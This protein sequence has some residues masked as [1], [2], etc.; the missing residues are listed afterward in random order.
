MR[1]R[2]GFGRHGSGLAGMFHTLAVNAQPVPLMA[3]PMRAGFPAHRSGYEKSGLGPVGC[4]PRRRVRHGVMGRWGWLWVAVVLMAGIMG[5]GAGESAARPDG[6]ALAAELRRERPA[7]DLQTRGVLRLRDEEGRWGTPVPMTLDVR[8]IGLQWQA[9]YRALGTDGELRELLV[10]LH[11]E[12]QPT[13]YDYTRRVAI[14][15]ES[16]SETLSLRGEAAEIPFAESEFW[17]VDFGLEFLHWP[18]QR[19]TKHEMRKGR[20][21]W[22]LESSR[23]VTNSIAGY[24]RVLSW[25]DIEHH[26]ILRAEAYDRSGRLMKEFSIGGFKKVDGRW[27]L[28]SMEIRNERTD[29][30][31]RLEFDLEVPERIEPGAK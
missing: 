11:D 21:C 26:G 25:V 13:R 2:S 31:T 10:V 5:A 3:Q 19:I 16:G 12:T 29:A 1:D 20:S 30:R 4:R 17:L 9:E 28:K 27:H 18:G 24:A 8:T 14:S 22:V 23:P 7:E 15:G 6:Q